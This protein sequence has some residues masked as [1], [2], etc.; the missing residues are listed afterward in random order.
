MSTFSLKCQA[1]D[2]HGMKTGVR[3][4][5]VGKSRQVRHCTVA[6]DCHWKIFQRLNFFNFKIHFLFLLLY[7]YFSLTT[8]FSWKFFALIFF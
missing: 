6:E 4:N 5:D 7:F 3:N 1:C 2:H 8:I